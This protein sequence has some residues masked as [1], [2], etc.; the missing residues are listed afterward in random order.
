MLNKTPANPLRANM[1]ARAGATN[2]KR[3]HEAGTLNRF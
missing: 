3:M 2:A 1:I